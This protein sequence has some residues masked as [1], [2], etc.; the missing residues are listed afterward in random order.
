MQQQSKGFSSLELHRLGVHTSTDVS[1]SREHICDG[2]SVHL[3]ALYH[4]S[5]AHDACAVAGSSARSKAEAQGAELG[6][7]R[8]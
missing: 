6:M 7:L 5:D 2:P 1:M 8:G 4:D 3:H